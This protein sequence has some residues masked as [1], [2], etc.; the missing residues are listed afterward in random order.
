MHGFNTFQ[1]D[2]FRYPEK[3]ARCAKDEVAATW[4]VVHCTIEFPDGPPTGMGGEKRNYNNYVAKV[5]ICNPCH[6]ALAGRARLCWG[7]GALVGSVTGLG[8]L[9]PMINAGIKLQGAFLCSTAAGVVVMIVVGW[10]AKLIAVDA[11]SFAK[12]DGL[13]PKIKFKNKDYQAAFDRLNAPT[14]QPQD[15]A[16]AW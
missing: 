13:A 15:Y 14:P 8:L 12:L 1:V 7:A 5:P 6:G 2:V 4:D 3:C 11:F 16:R 10:L 9:L